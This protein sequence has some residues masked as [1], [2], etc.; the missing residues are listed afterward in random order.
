MLLLDN[1]DVD[2]LETISTI[3]IV[4]LLHRSG[5]VCTGDAS[6]L[7]SNALLKSRWMISVPLSIFRSSVHWWKYSN[8][9]VTHDHPD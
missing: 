3:K 2:L 4:C 5:V 9:W 7:Q 8:S 1:S 6:G